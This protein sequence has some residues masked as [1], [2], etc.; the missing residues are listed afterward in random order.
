[1]AE[2]QSSHDGNGLHETEVH[3][4]GR[5]RGKE[6]GN[7]D[8]QEGQCQKGVRYFARVLSQSKS[9]GGSR[10]V[11]TSKRLSKEN[12]EEVDLPLLRTLRT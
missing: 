10:S 6:E 11:H 4:K 2:R 9:K 8:A 3:G 1:M 5:M 7:G 12:L